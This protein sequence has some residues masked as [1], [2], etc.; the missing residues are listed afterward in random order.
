MAWARFLPKPPLRLLN[1]HRNTNK[2]PT[3][4][5]PNTK[6]CHGIKSSLVSATGGCSATGA[7][8]GGA[9]TEA[10]LAT[11]SEAAALA[12]TADAAEAVAGVAAEA[13]A[14]GALAV[15]TGAA[16]ATAAAGAEAVVSLA[17]A[18]C[19]ATAMA[20]AAPAAAPA[21]VAGACTGRRPK[22]FNSA[23]V[24][25]YTF[26]PVNARF[27]LPLRNKCGLARIIARL[28]SSKLKPDGRTRAAIALSVSPDLA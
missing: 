4:T 2:A 12:A 3:P 6:A 9:T 14:T 22:R 19:G 8:A 1:A 17:V 25:I 10:S 18:S 26:A 24:G 28:V 7:G 5:P 23:V 11:A 27:T 15:V 21:A 16:D 13:A 20:A